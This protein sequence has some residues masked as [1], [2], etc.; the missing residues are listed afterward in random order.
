MKYFVIINVSR[1][2]LRTKLHLALSCVCVCGFFVVLIDTHTAWFH[3]LLYMDVP[4]CAAVRETP[5]SP[6]DSSLEGILV[7]DKRRRGSGKSKKGAHG[8]AEDN[9]HR[10]SRSRHLSPMIPVSSRF[11][12]HGTRRLYLCARA[13]V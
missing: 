1:V 5:S 3:A 8:A 11:E 13:C 7:G 9:A 12:N 6:L 4:P 10:N 2:F